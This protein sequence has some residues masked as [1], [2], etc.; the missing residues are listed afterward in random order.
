MSQSLTFQPTSPTQGSQL[1]YQIKSKETCCQR[2]WQIT[3]LALSI[4]LFPLGCIRIGYH[5]LHS[6]TG[7]KIVSISKT[8]QSAI[9]ENFR[10]THQGKQIKLV[11]PDHI[12]LQ[13]THLPGNGVSTD[14]QTAI[15]FCGMGCYDYE[16]YDVVEMY[17]KQGINVLLFNY[18]GVGHS[19]GYPTKQGLIT[20]GEAAVRLLN[21][22]FHVPV[23]QI[24]LHGHSFG[25]GIAAA[26]GKRFKEAALCLDRSFT[27]LVRCMRLL[28]NWIGAAFLW[29]LGWQLDCVKDSKAITGRKCVVYNT[30]DHLQTVSPYHVWKNQND[31]KTQLLTMEPFGDSSTTSVRGGD[32]HMRA[33]FEPEENQLLS[34]L[35]N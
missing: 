27:S 19:Q 8:Y 28:T 18:R 31:P 35:K 22:H 29:L 32:A 34:F 26:V 14:S 16:Y 25:G 33:F 3:Y 2:M 15:I 4:L 12:A 5:L 9:A 30:R 23:H 11:T 13:A 21:E 20:D 1:T 7:K 17:Q 6:I 10:Q 24:I